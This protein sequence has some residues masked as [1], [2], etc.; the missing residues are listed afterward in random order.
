[1]RCIPCEG[2]D[3]EGWV[4]ARTAPLL[5]EVDFV[6]V[7][8]CA[9]LEDRDAGVFFYESERNLFLSSVPTR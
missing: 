5:D 2:C 8:M 7:E 4:G 6:A 3:Y 1:M 9:A